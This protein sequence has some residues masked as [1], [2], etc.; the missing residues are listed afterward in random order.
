ML[1]DYAESFEDGK[2]S[3][4]PE[5]MANIWNAAI[6]TMAA[7]VSGVWITIRTIYDVTL[8]F[9]FNAI[10]AAL[11]FLASSWNSIWTAIQSVTKTVWNTLLTLYDATLRPVWNAFS[12]SLTYIHETWLSIWRDFTKTVENVWG[13]LQT[14]YN[15][16]LKPVWNEF[17]TAL[18]QILGLIQ[19]VTNS[20]SS[21]FGSFSN[22][23]KLD[24]TT[25][26]L[27]G[28]MHVPGFA[29][30]GVVTSPTL[31]MVGEAGPEA[32]IPLSSIKSQSSSQPAQQN[33]NIN[34]SF[35]VSNIDAMSDFDW[36]TNINRRLQ[37][38]ANELAV[39]LS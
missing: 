38:I 16:T 31:A 1:G 37:N 2:E 32:I 4:V 7:I 24:T 15:A 19:S 29:S 14:I 25:P 27:F 5:S 23:G 3:V 9:V 34:V 11:V 6:G 21:L 30:G 18:T 10:H 28:G 20:L 35:S 12:N 8:G 22:F 13:S 39:M 26:G 36:Q 17:I 33:N